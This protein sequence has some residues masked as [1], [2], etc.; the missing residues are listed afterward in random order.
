[1]VDVKFE[2]VDHLQ[3]VLQTCAG[4]TKRIYIAPTTEVDHTVCSQNKAKEGSIHRTF[5]MNISMDDSITSVVR[6]P[7][8][9]VIKAF[10]ES[11]ARGESHIMSKE[12]EEQ[13]DS[14][15]HSRFDES[16]SYQQSFNDQSLDDQFSSED[17]ERGSEDCNRSSQPHRIPNRM[18]SRVVARMSPRLMCK[19]GTWR[20]QTWEEMYSDLCMYHRQHG[21][22]LVNT[23]DTKL[24]RWVQMQRRRHKKGE[25]DDNHIRSLESIGF[26]WELHRGGAQQYWTDMF[27]E[28]KAYKL[29]NGDCRVPRRKSKLG[30]WV[31]EQRD[32]HKKGELDDDQI[33]CLESIG[34]VWDAHIQS[35]LDM[36]EELKT[37]KEENGDCHV[38]LKEGKLGRWVCNQREK[39]KK[40][41]LDE[42]QISSLESIGFTWD[43]YIQIWIDMFEK[44]KAYEKEN[45][46]C[47]V[48]GSTPKLGRWVQKQ[49]EKHKKG[50]LDEDQFRCLESIGF[51]WGAHIQTWMN[52]FDDLKRYKK[53]NGDCHV[54]RSTPKLG[55]WVSK[56]REKLK[57]GKLDVDQIRCLDS[58]GF[59][60]KLREAMSE[61]EEQSDSN[62]RRRFDESES[63]QQSFN[64]QSLDD[65][66]SSEDNEMDVEGCNR[67]SQPHRIPNRKRSRVVAYTSHRLIR[68]RETYRVQTWEE[69]Y[70]DLCMY[71]RQHG[72][73]LVNTIDTKLGPWVRLQREIHKKEEL[74]DN[75]IRSLESIGFV[76]ELREANAQQ[77]WND[78]FEELKAYKEEIGDCHV[79]TRKWKLGRWV[80]MQRE[81]YKKGELDNDQI[82]CFE[83]IGFVWDVH[84]QSWLDMFEELKTYKEENGDCHVPLKEGK[85]GGWVCNQREKHKK[86]DLDDKK[87]RC[88][89]SIGFMWES[90][91]KHWIDM[92]E[93]L[94]AYKKENGDCLVPART[95]DLGWWVRNQRRKHK[96]GELEENQFRS[97][98]AI[99]FAWGA[100]IQTWMEMFEKLKTY[101]KENG[102]C[103]VPG[104][105]K[106][107]GRWV[108]TQRE[109]YKKGKL[110]EDQLRCLESIGFVWKLRKTGGQQTWIEM[111][112]GLKAYKEDNGDCLSTTS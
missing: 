108:Q 107:L 71:H 51:A 59:V 69:M 46:D 25:L 36:F 87:T 7:R 19:R 41:E 101:E 57:K 23:S 72:D 14:N 17:N 80:Q 74:D 5:L 89:E 34:F 1:M 98:D 82:R 13:S 40:G 70:S 61:E 39:H 44:L 3:P 64:D 55:R 109:N 83:S 104:S 11:T 81:K 8:D 56:Q 88:L 106:K 58:I 66:F 102:D 32:K 63:H 103:L 95:I 105:T 68:K 54:P 12:E 52:M 30:G 112:E 24:G 65:Q 86:G 76:W 42:D 97:L 94:K 85:L 73:C 110:D 93:K 78:M 29:E 45:G 99:G 100:Q 22:C 92:F 43:A 47:L 75:Q 60:W 33:R 31:H 35:W 50:K 77:L 10:F 18:K 9:D 4:N 53:E 16:E 96:K 49:R 6:D 84:I 21:D 15:E 91:L 48:P 79:P 67:S 27:E 28:L 2:Y 37:Y 62:E 20:V 38:P 90:R 111:F 26:V